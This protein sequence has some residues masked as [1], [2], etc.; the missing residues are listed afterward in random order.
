MNQNKVKLCNILLQ[1]DLTHSAFLK[2]TWQFSPEHHLKTLWTKDSKLKW[3]HCRCCAIMVHKGKNN[4]PSLVH[5][6]IALTAM[7]GVTSVLCSGDFFWQNFNLS[8]RWYLA[9]W[10]NLRTACRNL[11]ILPS[12]VFSLVLRFFCLRRVLGN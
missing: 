1:S 3:H 5:T 12:L 11:M 4:V 8:L 7:I 6:G 2:V 9:L 10:A